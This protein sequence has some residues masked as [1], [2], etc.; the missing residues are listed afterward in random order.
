[1]IIKVDS[2]GK[3]INTLPEIVDIITLKFEMLQGRYKLITNNKYLQNMQFTSDE[4]TEEINAIDTQS[5][6][7]YIFYRERQEKTMQKLKE[8]KGEEL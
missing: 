8:I 4:L 5:K 7:E 6:L 3:V 1:M 2:D